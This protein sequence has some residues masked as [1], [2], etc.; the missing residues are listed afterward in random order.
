MRWPWRWFRSRPQPEPVNGTA[1][2]AAA[3]ERAAIAEVRANRKL[4]ESLAGRRDVRR[5]LDGF[6]AAVEA[7]L[8]RK[9]HQ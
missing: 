9:R 7:A 2:A 6:A 5:E 1:P 3:A 8:A 4:D